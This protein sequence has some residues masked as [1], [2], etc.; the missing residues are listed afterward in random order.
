MIVHDL[1]L[2]QKLLCMKSAG[3]LGEFTPQAHRTAQ[4]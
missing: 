4:K 1:V 3:I 2:S